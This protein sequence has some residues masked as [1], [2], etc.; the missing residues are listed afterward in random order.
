MVISKKEHVFS[1]QLLIEF[2]L[3]VWQICENAYDAKA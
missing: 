3:Q 2:H 1:S